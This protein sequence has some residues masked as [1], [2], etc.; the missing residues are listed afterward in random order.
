MNG[1]IRCCRCRLHADQRRG[2]LP[3]AR[4]KRANQDA[5]QTLGDPRLDHRRLLIQLLAYVPGVHSSNPIESSH[6][7]GQVV[8]HD[9]KD[10]TLFALSS[11]NRLGIKRSFWR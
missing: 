11:G 3:T 1:L 4:H 5:T 8:A 6:Q 9:S 10:G 2:A 7:R